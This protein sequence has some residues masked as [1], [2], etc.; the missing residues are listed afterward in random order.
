MKDQRHG[1]IREERPP[2]I[3]SNHLLSWRY[4]STG[5]ARLRRL[6]ST[7][8]SSFSHSPCLVHAPLLTRPRPPLLS[9]IPSPAASRII[10]HTV[11]VPSARRYDIIRMARHHRRHTLPLLRAQGFQSISTN[12]LVVE[13]LGFVMRLS[14]IAMNDVPLQ[15]VQVHSPISSF[16]GIPIVVVAPAAACTPRMRMLLGYRL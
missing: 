8:C 15:P 13:G 6:I 7:G 3:T 5:E 9:L 1:R 10:T 12:I 14:A 4:P 11:R 2:P 16:C